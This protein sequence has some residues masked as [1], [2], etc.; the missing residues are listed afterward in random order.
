MSVTK[1]CN[2]KVSAIIKGGEQGRMA[3]ML[4]G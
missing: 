1:Y 3:G 4:K 2:S